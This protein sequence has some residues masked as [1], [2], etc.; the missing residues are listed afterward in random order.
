MNSYRES[1]LTI[2]D[3][4]RSVALVASSGEEDARLLIL[5]GRIGGKTRATQPSSLDKSKMSA[6]RATPLAVFWAG[7]DTGLK[8]RLCHVRVLPWSFADGRFE[9]FI[10]SAG[11]YLK[12][13]PE[14][15]GEY[16]QKV[17]PSTN[18]FA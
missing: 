6:E 1:L 16:H 13:K 9:A 18:L 3:I 5:C 15:S 14:Y 12:Y 2:L 10:W 4:H 17:R 7:L 11:C 8:C